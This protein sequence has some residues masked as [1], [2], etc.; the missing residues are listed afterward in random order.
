MILT[1]LWWALFRRKIGRGFCRCCRIAIRS[2]VYGVARC[3]SAVICIPF[4]LFPHCLGHE[5]TDGLT[6]FYILPYMGSRYWQQRGLQYFDLLC[7]WISW[8]RFMLLAPVNIERVIGK[9]M[10]VVLPA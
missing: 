9:D 1:S 3:P 4:N 10:G 8:D 6:F 2:A 7:S 5:V